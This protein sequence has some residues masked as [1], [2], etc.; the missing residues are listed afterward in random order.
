GHSNLLDSLLSGTRSAN[1]PDEGLRDFGLSG[2]GIRSLRQGKR[3]P[4]P[5]TKRKGSLGRPDRRSQPPP[6]VLSCA[7]AWP[8]GIRTVR[9][10]PGEPPFPRASATPLRVPPT[11]ANPCRAG[12][13]NGRVPPRSCARIHW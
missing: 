13:G 10:G 4:R 7:R 11:R 12:T 9:G 5:I 6:T 2:R 1:W 3:E 8:P